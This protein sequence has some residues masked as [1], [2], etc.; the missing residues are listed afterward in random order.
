VNGP[1]HFLDEARALGPR[2]SA[3][4][5][6][7]HR[8]PELGLDCPE[9]S[10]LVQKELLALGLEVRGGLAR[11]GIAAVLR[12]GP[13]PAAALR[14]DLDALPL[15][16]RTGL[17][18][19]SEIPG[20][21]HACGHDG[22]TALGLGV[23]HLL[24]PRAARLGGD[25]LL[26]FQPGEE[27]PGGARPMIAEGALDDPSP[28]VILGCHLNPG[29]PLG[30]VAVCSG[31]AT[32]GNE[33]FTIT[34]TGQGG[35][36]ARPRDCRN[37]IPPA[38]RLVLELEA[39]AAGLAAGPEP[40][41]L[42]VAQFQAGQGHNVIPQSVEL[43]GTLR[44]F[45]EEVRRAALANMDRICRDLEAAEGVAVA[46]ASVT[47]APPMVLPPDLAGRV[48]DCCAELLGPERVDLPA[49]T[50]M[51]AEDFAF[52]AQARPASYLRLGCGDA[53]R[54]HGLHTPFFDFDEAL[55]PEAC[56]VLAWC[57]LR[58]LRG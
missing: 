25:L 46:L 48:R 3:W 24:A 2:L 58:L 36:A 27:H 28:A 17:P 52:F 33:E 50:S 19:A 39:L 30:R 16:E 49:E 10:A 51:G 42:T 1:Q 40:A 5:R 11:S 37:P 35:H 34:L 21:M 7:L 20:R 14:V 56:A 9:A 8:R 55:L 41:V 18:F 6:A 47:D 13:G 22:H 57:L 26:L 23:A 12:G 4:R 15:E 38:A 29:L 32:A 45:Q 31:P 54:T 53:V 43:K 44:F